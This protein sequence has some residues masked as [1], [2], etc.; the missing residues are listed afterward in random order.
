MAS[1]E[2][3]KS[4]QLIHLH[5]NKFSLAGKF[6]FTSRKILFHAEETKLSL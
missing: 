5:E 1:E 6:I 4:F 3:D 2:R